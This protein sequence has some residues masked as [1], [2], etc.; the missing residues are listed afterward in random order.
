VKGK[1]LQHYL[2]LNDSL[3]L[4]DPGM[5]KQVLEQEATHKRKL[6]L[7]ME[8]KEKRREAEELEK[9]ASRAGR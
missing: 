7:L 1:R 9:K 6:E 3:Y 8:A 5:R 4:A 2:Y